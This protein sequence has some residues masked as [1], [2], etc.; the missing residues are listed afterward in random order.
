MCEKEEFLND[1][2]TSPAIEQ[3]LNSSIDTY[4]SFPDSN[5]R[6]DSL[7][8]S[9]AKKRPNSLTIITPAKLRIGRPEDDAQRHLIN[10]L[11]Q[12]H[13]GSLLIPLL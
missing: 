13:L 6:T 11:C 8:A 1:E 7:S 5:S 9:M 10:S 4:V 12:R 2:I 3:S